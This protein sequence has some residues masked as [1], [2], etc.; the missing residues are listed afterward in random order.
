MLLIQLDSRAEAL[1]APCNRVPQIDGG[2]GR[3]DGK[4]LR[5]G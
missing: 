3:E 4:G 5:M 1:R 2:G